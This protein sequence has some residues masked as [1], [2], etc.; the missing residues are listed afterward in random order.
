MRLWH[1]PTVNDV[2]LGRIFLGARKRFGWRQLDVAVQNG[3]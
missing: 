2:R 3:N 1:G